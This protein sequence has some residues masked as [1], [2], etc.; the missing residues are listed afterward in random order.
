MSIEVFD[1]YI[2]AMTKRGP[3][4]PVPIYQM[5]INTIKED[6]AAGTLA[7]GQ[8]LPTEA[9]LGEIHQASRL[10]V[11]RALEVLREEGVVYTIRADGS[12]V[13]P[14]DAPQ[15]R[16]PRQHEQIAADLAAGVKR[17]VYGPD[18][19]LPSQ[20]ELI[21]QYGV[22]KKTVSAA[23]ALLRG[24]GWAYTVPAIGTFAA[25]RD[26]WPWTSQEI[27][28]DVIERIER[29]GHAPYEGLPSES[30]MMEEYGVDN[31]TAHA[32]IA[33]LLAQS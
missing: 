14:R 33:L 12:Y 13:G 30:E 22:A 24:Q 8:A 15:I 16:E 2:P 32:A 4:G 20:L 28:A 23:V 17:G 26:K 27:A 21:E 1:M 5:I 9:E 25:H 7:P 6:I 11:R 29:G 19:V 31:E 3:R 18:Q 10:T